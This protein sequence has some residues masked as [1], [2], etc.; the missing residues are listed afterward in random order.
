MAVIETVAPRA[1]INY[2]YAMYIFISS[3]F[4]FI[5]IFHQ[6]YISSIVKQLLITR[7]TFVRSYYSY[8]SYRLLDVSSDKLSRQLYPFNFNY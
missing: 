7:V 8:A 4:P 2:R 1:T 5:T 3:I 6:K